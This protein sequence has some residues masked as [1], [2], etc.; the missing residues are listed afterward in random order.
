MEPYAN[1]ELSQNADLEVRY[2]LASRDV[3]NVSAT[4]SPILINEA[5]RQISSG[6][7][8]K[9]RLGPDE[10]DT[11]RFFDNWSFVFDQEFTG[12]G[13]DTKLSIS[14]LALAARKNISESGFALRTRFEFGA[15]VGRSGEKARVSERF[16]LGGAA[17]RG[18]ERGTIS[19]RDVCTGCA[20]GGGDQITELGGNYYAVARTDL[21]VPIFQN[22]PDLETFAFF[23][24]GSVWST[25]TTTAPSG[26]LD[27][28]RRLRSSAGV[29]LSF[30]TALG[31][32]E[33][34]L[35]LTTNAERYDEEEVF[36]LLFR[37]QF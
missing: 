11:N 5:G 36:G 9:L 4:A 6:I 35:A 28:T 21:L 32:F 26:V 20:A 1:F 13:G 7:G 30:A 2:V 29:G 14:R 24:F 17:L 10:N 31:D 3:R 15:A 16:T 8:F 34:Y 33:A 27:D 25:N 18:F 12:L 37:A 23:D 22:A 19:P